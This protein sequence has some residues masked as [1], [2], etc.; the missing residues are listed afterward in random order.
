MVA[1]RTPVL[2]GGKVGSSIV[3]PSMMISIKKNT[4]NAEETLKFVHWFE[5]NKEAAVL[6]TDSRGVPPTEVQRKSAQEAGKIDPEV[7]K[8]VEMGIKNMALDENAL[9]TNSELSTIMKNQ[10]EKVAFGKMTPE[11]AAEESMT[12]FDEKLKQLKTSRK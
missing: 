3:R 5:N 2:K 12:L 4:S 10:V 6:L 1:V 9:T 8:G 7:V 11:Q